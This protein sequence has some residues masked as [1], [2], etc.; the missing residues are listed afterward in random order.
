MTVLLGHSVC[1]CCDCVVGS[2]CVMV[3]QMCCWV[4][5]CAGAVTVLLVHS[6]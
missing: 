4:T 6:V 2:Q 5:V 1:W 3:M